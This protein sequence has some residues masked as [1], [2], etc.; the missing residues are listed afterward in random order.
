[1]ISPTCID[2]CSLPLNV[3]VRLRRVFAYADCLKGTNIIHAAVGIAISLL[4]AF[5]SLVLSI[6]DGSDLNPHSKAYYAS[7]CGKWTFRRAF[8]KSVLPLIAAAL[9]NYIHLRVCDTVLSTSKHNCVY[10]Q[11]HLT[12]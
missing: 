9:P 3:A 7:P 10:M 4:F 6:A 11:L 2:K 8:I 5:I 1:V 12:P